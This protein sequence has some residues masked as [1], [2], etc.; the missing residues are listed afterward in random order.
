MSLFQDLKLKRRKTSSVLVETS[1]STSNYV[2]TNSS[3]NSPNNSPILLNQL[4]LQRT[5]SPTNKHLN[6]QTNGGNL[7]FATGS[8][9]IVSNKQVVEQVNKKNQNGQACTVIQC[10]KTNSI[11]KLNNKSVIQQY[12][13][14]SFSSSNSS[15]SPPSSS[16]PTPLS[17]SS[18]C[19]NSLQNS[20][21]QNFNNHPLSN[22]HSSKLINSNTLVAKFNLIV[23][24]LSILIGS[25]FL[26][27]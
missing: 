2:Q 6:S 12:R 21:H 20:N 5:N 22:N 8:N 25:S 7:I 26:E 24:D 16:P 15:L 27:N 13:S 18:T 23:V 17:L 9:V 4:L 10:G 1:K 3:I 19:T 14:N 11:N